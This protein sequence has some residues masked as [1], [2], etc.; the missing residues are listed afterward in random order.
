MNYSYILY[1]QY[2]AVNPQFADVR[3][4]PDMGYVLYFYDRPL[5]STFF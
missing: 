4:H 2:Y 3:V 1:M 5:K